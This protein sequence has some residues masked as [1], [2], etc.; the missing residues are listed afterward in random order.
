MRVGDLV[1]FKKAMVEDPP[2]FLVYKTYRDGR[3]DVVF[4]ANEKGKQGAFS[5]KELTPVSSTH[6]V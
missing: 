4:L 5:V 3:V 1:K 2:L 6:E